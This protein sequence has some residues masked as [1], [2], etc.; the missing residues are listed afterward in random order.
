M[1]VPAYSGSSANGRKKPS[2]R[3]SSVA[4]KHGR[5]APRS[6]HC[7]P[8]L[9]WDDGWPGLPMPGYQKRGIGSALVRKGLKALARRAVPLVF[10][11]GDLGYYS[12]FGHPDLAGAHAV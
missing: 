2:S 1:R 11:E 7:E 8:L 5:T 6:K 10:L 3:N 4:T 9:P 12:R